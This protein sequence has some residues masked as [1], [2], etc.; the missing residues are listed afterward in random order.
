[1]KHTIILNSPTVNTAQGGVEKIKSDLE[2]ILPT[3]TLEDF[4][5]LE[6]SLMNSQNKRESLVNNFK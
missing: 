1:M 2:V 4:L 5:Q 6:N 3:V